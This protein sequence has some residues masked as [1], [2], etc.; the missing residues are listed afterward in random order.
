MVCCVGAG[1]FDNYNI[2]LYIRQIMSAHIISF[3]FYNIFEY[4]KL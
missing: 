4:E 2:V 1:H 3:D